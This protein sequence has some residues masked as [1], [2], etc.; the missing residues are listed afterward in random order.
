MDQM[1]DGRRIVSILRD[2]DPNGD[3]VQVLYREVIKGEGP[4]LVRVLRLG[5]LME[6]FALVRYWR[7]ENGEEGGYFSDKHLLV[8][9]Q[10]E[11]ASG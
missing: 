4:A 8:P 2:D 10:P 9:M 1:E 11:G 6:K 5:S 7:K 3:E